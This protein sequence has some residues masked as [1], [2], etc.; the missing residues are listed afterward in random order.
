MAPRVWIEKVCFP[1]Q[2]DGGGLDAR[3]WCDPEGIQREIQ[4]RT[5]G[6]GG[7]AAQDGL[8]LLGKTLERRYLR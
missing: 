4:C 5:V 1:L 7:Q 2:T 6:T 3:P 8:S